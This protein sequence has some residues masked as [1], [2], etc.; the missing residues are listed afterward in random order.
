V[1]QLAL[2][3]IPVTFRKVDPS[4]AAV[5]FVLKSGSTQR[6]WDS[7]SAAL[8]M[9]QVLAA[10]NCTVIEAQIDTGMGPAPFAL[11][12]ILKPQ[13]LTGEAEKLLGVSRITTPRIIAVVSP[14]SRREGIGRALVTQLLDSARDQELKEV[15]VEAERGHT[16]FFEEHF[17]FVARNGAVRDHYSDVGRHRLYMLDKRLK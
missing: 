13:P 12:V 1:K 16:A 2:D 17:G 7:N 4:Q 11:G 3:G 8:A 10:G 5:Q 14:D 9:K 6:V 15:E